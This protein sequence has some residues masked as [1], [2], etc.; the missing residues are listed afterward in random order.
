MADVTDRDPASPTRRLV[1]IAWGSFVLIGWTSVLVPALLRQIE[2]RFGVDDA[3]IGIYYFVYSASYASASFLCGLL[4]E[5][6]GR[7]VVLSGMAALMGLGLLATG[8]AP[9]WLVFLAAAVPLGAGAGAIDGGVNGLALAIFDEGRGRALNLLHLFFA[10]GALTA[11]VVVGQLVERGI[12][13]APIFVVTGVAALAVAVG[14][15]VTPMPSGLRRPIAFGEASANGVRGGSASGGAGGSGSL[16][17]PLALLALAIGCYVASEVGVSN[18]I[19]RFLAAAPV[20]LA[21]AALS[22]FW[23]GLAA[24]RLFAAR[25]SDRF[26]H[27]AFAAIASVVTGI[28]VIAGVVAPTPELSLIAFAISGFGSGPIFPM[29]VALGGELYPDRLSATTGTL[30][31]A[32]VV[33]GTI[34][35]PLIGLMSASFGLATGLLG[36]AVLSFACAGAILL[37]ARTRE[38]RAGRMSLDAG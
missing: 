9:G 24:G 3:A 23:G 29:I 25:Y 31:G 8:F 22:A 20:T 10:A 14:L 36:A 21:T 18:W 13:W 27:T 19:V 15:R 33:G 2:A 5:R 1:R 34:Y 30:T 16:L 12:A 28:A 35:P 7:S 37:A 17:V 38:Q 11:P 26:S 32:A 6:L 4:T